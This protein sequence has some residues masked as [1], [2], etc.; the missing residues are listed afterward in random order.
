LT[1]RVP[2]ALTPTGSSWT[3]QVERWFGLM[4]RQRITRSAHKNGQALGKDIHPWSADWNTHPQAVP[5][6]QYHR[7]APRVTHPILSTD[8]R[9]RTLAD[10]LGTVVTHHDSGPGGITAIANRACGTDGP[11]RAGFTDHP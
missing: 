4:A 2:R 8:S 3:D 9:R 7:R 11:D 1:I 6:D 5:V 10:R